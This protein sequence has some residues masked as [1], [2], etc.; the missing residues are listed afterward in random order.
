MISRIYR[1]SRHYLTIN[2]RGLTAAPPLRCFI[3]S[4]QFPETTGQI[5]H[6]FREAAPRREK[7]KRRASRKLQES[8]RKARDETRNLA[9][10]RE[11]RHIVLC[12]D[13]KIVRS[14]VRWF[15]AHPRSHL[16]SPAEGGA[17]C[18]RITASRGLT[19]YNSSRR[20]RTGPSISHD[21]FIVTHPFATPRRSLSRYDAYRAK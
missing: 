21:K 19:R 17:I 20:N 11:F 16:A 15:S 13:D 9:I 14:H 7:H 6:K 18:K 10:A 1:F 5:W 12:V 3:V 8:S 4:N 2:K